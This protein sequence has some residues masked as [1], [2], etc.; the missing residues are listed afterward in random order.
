MSDY[1]NNR[2]LT[3][4]L[5]DWFHAFLPNQTYPI[6]FE[7]RI[8]IATYKLLELLDEYDSHATFFVL[9]HVAENNKELIKEIANAGHEIGSHGFQHMCIYDLT[10]DSFREDLHK[11]VQLLE[12]LTGKSVRSY[13]APFFSILKQTIW[14][15]EIMRDERIKCDSSIFPIRNH[16]YGIPKA[17]RIPHQ[18]IPELW[19]WPITTLP[20]LMGNIP[21][22]G[23]CYFRF[24]PWKFILFAIRTIEKRDEPILI[25][26]HPWEM[27]PDQPRYRSNSWFLNFRHYYRLKY[28]EEKLRCLLGLGKF[29]SLS[30][31]INSIAGN[32]SQ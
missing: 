4:D 29:T 2:V 10:P 27:D 21:F 13:R 32:N 14:A 16:R 19:E 20:S 23:G 9:G 31:G 12:S 30:S 22:A 17:K 24:L 5:E 7:R 1:L 18:I 8:H 6:D 11:S 26:L 3:I 15:L 28:T 25:Y